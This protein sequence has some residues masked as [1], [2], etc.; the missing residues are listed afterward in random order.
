MQKTVYEVYVDLV[1]GQDFAVPT[2]FEGDNTGK[3]RA[4][5]AASDIMFAG[6]FKEG[7]GGVH[8]GTWYP[9]HRIA[10]VVIRTKLVIEE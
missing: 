6:V 4:M 5:E 7:D 1:S 10:S 9:P 3:A 2:T 8:V